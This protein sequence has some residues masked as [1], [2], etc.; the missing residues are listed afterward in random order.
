MKFFVGISEPSWA[1][2]FEK[3]EQLSRELGTIERLLD[4]L[5]TLEEDFLKDE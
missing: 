2:R 1:H 5:T 4:G 3:Y